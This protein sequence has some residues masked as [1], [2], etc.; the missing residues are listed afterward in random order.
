MAFDSGLRVAHRQRCYS[1]GMGLTP[2]PKVYATSGSTPSS[3]ECLLRSGEG[4]LKPTSWEPVGTFLTSQDH[5]PHPTLPCFKF[6]CQ[7]PPSPTAFGSPRSGHSPHNVRILYFLAASTIKDLSV[8]KL[9]CCL[10]LTALQ[11]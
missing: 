2:N 8:S 5:T 9:C 1:R 11:I 4:V 7:R 10:L 3:L 6:R